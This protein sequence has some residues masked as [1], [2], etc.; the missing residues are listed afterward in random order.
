[1][2]RVGTS[3]FSF[4][5]WI[6]NVYPPGTKSHQ[7]FSYYVE[8]LGFKC[9]ELNYTFYHQPEARTMGALLRNSPEDFRFT[10]KAHR[11]ITHQAPCGV[12]RAEFDAACGRY[13]EGIEPLVEAARLGCILAQF[14]HSFQANR[15]NLLFLELLAERFRG[16]EVVVEFRN[17]SWAREERFEWFSQLK[18]GVCAVDEP[19]VG[20]LMAFVPHFTSKIAY[21]RLHG[22]NEKWFSD[23]EGRY[24]YLYSR[25]ELAGLIPDLLD[26]EQRGLETYIMFNN[27]HAGAAARNAAMMR[28]LL[29]SGD[30]AQPQMF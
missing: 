5:G 18:L 22:R 11:S 9:L 30:T 26:A 21:F 1:M 25:E 4:R 16:F 28:E 3:G 8:R 10:A 6:G 12:S 7:M 27:C 20:S 29:G 19:K 14:P 15:S 13:L 24:D 23:P 2:I 17:Q